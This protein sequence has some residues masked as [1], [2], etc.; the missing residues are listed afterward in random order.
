LQPK[1]VSLEN[2]SRF[3]K[4][5]LKL[6]LKEGDFKWSPETEPTK[7]E[8]DPGSITIIDWLYIEDFATTNVIIKHLSDQLSK[9]GGILIVLSQL[10]E[11]GTWFAPNLIK[12][13]PAFAARY[14]YDNESDGTMGY[15]SVDAIRDPKSSIKS[16]KIP[17]QYDWHTR[18]L[19]RVDEL[20]NVTPILSKVN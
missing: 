15:W 18:L 16:T 1:Y 5:A 9:A 4:T 3:A 10:K 6:G 11:D 17:C 14:L 19:R 8:L 7:I 12:N 20:D 13:F 2:G